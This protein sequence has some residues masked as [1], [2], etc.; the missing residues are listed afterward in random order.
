MATRRVRTGTERWSTSFVD[1]SSE[2][3]LACLWILIGAGR[4]TQAILRDETWGAEASV[5]LG[6]LVFGVVELVRIL[7]AGAR[8]S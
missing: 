6:L 3:F 8:S 5:C 4:T 2:M 1:S 7:R